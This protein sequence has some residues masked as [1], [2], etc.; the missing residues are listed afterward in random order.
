MSVA[1]ILLEPSR[2]KINS[3]A[4]MAQTEAALNHLT[5]LWLFGQE[6]NPRLLDGK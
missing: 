3:A 6:R 5:F 2:A 1:I 4:L